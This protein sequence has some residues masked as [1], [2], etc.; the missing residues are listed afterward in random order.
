MH[1]T[2]AELT[3]FF[4]E[5]DHA[6]AQGSI[7]IRAFND[8]SIH[9]LE[10]DRIFTR[11]WVFVGHE[12][13]IPA[14]GDYVQRPIGRDPFILVRGEDGEIRVLFDACRHRGTMVCR[15]ESGNAA[16]F[17]CPYHG[18][19]YKN[20]GELAG[21]PFLRAAYGPDLDKSELGLL[22][23]P[24]VESL[25]GLVF[26]SLDPDA[27]SLNEYLGDMKWYLDMIWGQCEDGWEVVGDPQRYT[28]PGNWKTAA[29]NFAG[30][31]YHT[32]YL[33]RSTIETGIMGGVQFG[34][35]SEN[36]DGFHIQAG[37]GHNFIRFM[38]PAD[39]PGP[40]FFG[41][42]ESVTKLFDP[43]MLGPELYGAAN[44]TVGFVGTVFPNLS[45]VAFPFYH[46][47]PAGP[48]ATLGV[49][50]WEP[51]SPGEM[52]VWTWAMCPKGAP[53]DFRRESYR[54]T[55]GTFSAGG[56]FEAD[57]TD[58]WISIARSA[59]TAY[60]RKVGMKIDYRMGMSGSAD[61]KRVDDY[62][63]PGV[64][65]WNV[66]EEGSIRGFH[67]RWLQFMRAADYPAAM[68]P[69][70]QNAGAGVPGSNGGG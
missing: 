9:E 53:E 51:R 43:D 7:P 29:E 21:V 2:D 52:I 17:R 13:E 68:T 54:T 23:A 4:D 28:L 67:R 40:H 55:M 33:H 59:D 31:D 61:S 19:T 36:L 14:R 58:P 26:A 65:F 1:P 70:E 60:G 39:V 12:S 69:E 18:W 5:F 56:T 47:R 6:L 49:H 63:D 3:E 37:N 50:L 30:D 11:A 15:A 46:D 22:A 64:A 48:V 32:F 20:T 66:L 41:Y 38:M 24:H 44:N 57:D 62:P 10:L 45:F 16:L 35:I 34:D 8:A 42:P 25:H 27:P